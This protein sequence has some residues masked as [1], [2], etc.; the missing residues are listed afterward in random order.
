M[1]QNPTFS[2]SFLPLKLLELRK[3]KLKKKR[4]D[5]IF[6][7]KLS[8]GGL[9][10]PTWACSKPRKFL[11]SIF[12]LSGGENNYSWFGRGKSVENPFLSLFHVKIVFF[13]EKTQTLTGKPHRKLQFFRKN[14][15]NQYKFP[16][17]RGKSVVENLFFSRKIG[18]NM[19]QFQYEILIFP[20]GKSM[21]NSDFLI[22]FGNF[23]W[24]FE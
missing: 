14:W 4:N 7:S 21:E 3:R 22:K 1:A 17:V 16:V 15:E 5:A 20:G 19:Q 12:Q 24:I 8:C 18:E 10:E 6:F 11:V 23:C 9:R 13:Y 2:V